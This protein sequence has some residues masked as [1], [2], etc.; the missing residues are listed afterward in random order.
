VPEVLVRSERAYLRRGSDAAFLVQP[1]AGR[2][3]KLNAVAASI[4]EELGSP[5]T[6][7]ELHAR[8]M[9]RFDVSAMEC[10]EQTDRF[11][12]QLEA[13]GL[14]EALDEPAAE[15]A[16]RR[17]YLDLLKRAL[18]NLIYPEDALRLE[19]AHAEERGGDP[20]EYQPLLRD[21]RYRRPE[22][23]GALLAA[24]REGGVAASFGA[25]LSHTMI[26][27]SGLDNL[28]RCAARVFGDGVPGDFLEAG[29]CH[30]GA[31][32]FMRAL[33]VAYGEEQRRTW[34]A[35][36]F[37]G[38][39]EPSHAVD[40]EHELHLSE[41]RHPWMAAGIGAVRDN[42][43]TYDL[44]SDRVCFLPGLF[45]D[46]LPTA[47]VE[48]LAILRIDG[49]LYSS[50]RDALTALYDRVS[51]GGFVIVDDYGCLEPCRLAVDEFIA[52]RN[53]DVE[54]CTVDWTRVCWRKPE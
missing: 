13:L 35:D 39:P 43:A 40:R 19:L 1:A 14:V 18:S 44:L 22:A 53:L 2:Q 6:R 27:V 11:V 17:R 15:S 50:T 38:V 46:T 30:G 49:D 9:A 20:L 54:I 3:L 52:E 47:P 24:K 7:D 31:S 25:L 5:I 23:Y 37:S 8:L 4:A 33:Q 51:A 28:E 41:P 10:A 42:F 48:R 26:G 21:V 12:E 45:A 16:M 32:I 34:V 36:S 29:V